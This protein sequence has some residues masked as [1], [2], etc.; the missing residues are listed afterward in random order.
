M[1]TARPEKIW[2]IIFLI[3]VA[4][5]FPVPKLVR[6]AEKPASITVFYHGTGQDG[7]KILLSGAEFSL[8]K[9]GKIQN[10]TGVP[11]EPFSEAGVSLSGLTAAGQKQAAEKLYQ[12]I[13]AHKISGSETV[14]QGSGYGVFS[15]LERGVYLIAQ[16]EDLPYDGGV[17]LS[18][19]FLVCIPQL[20]ENGME[21]LDIT[22]EPKNQWVPGETPAI[23]AVPTV[24]PVTKKEPT[25]GY[26]GSGG[27]TY[28][29]ASSKKGT[30]SSPVRTGDETPV[31]S[32]LG[33]MLCG[34]AAAFMVIR[35][36]RNGE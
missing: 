22:V 9:V 18:A 26:S 21:V 8:Y 23:T 14:I 34:G 12:Y 6:A 31:L 25:P 30:S 5:F 29:G 15:N 10:G 3:A 2:I 1:K 33:L 24:T 36:K 4:A 16:K 27:S 35:R 13:L 32:F 7:K 28:G 11:E 19:P 17:F 20:D